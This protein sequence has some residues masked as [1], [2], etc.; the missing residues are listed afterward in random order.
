MVSDS[1]FLSNFSF[2]SFPLPSI[3]VL[4]RLGSMALFLFSVPII[5]YVGICLGSCGQQIVRYCT[6]SPLQAIV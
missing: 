4:V 5:R 2:F 3:A 6:N 1:H